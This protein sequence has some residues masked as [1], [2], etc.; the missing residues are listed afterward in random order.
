MNLIMVRHAHDIP[1]AGAEFKLSIQGRKQARDTADKI[2][3]LGVPSI[4]AA[5]S[6]P[7]QRS[8]ET[9]DE[10][11]TVLSPE[12]RDAVTLLQP[13]SSVADLE[14]L[15]FDLAPQKPNTIILVGHEP[16]LSN[17]VLQWCGLPDNDQLDDGRPPW[18]LA[19]GEAMSVFPDVVSSTVY[20]HSDLIQM[21]GRKRPLPHSKPL[22][23]AGVF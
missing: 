5:L 15:L 2:A 14:T 12:R 16:Q 10:M 1:G 20:L 22:S 18:T 19:R 6:S 4:D 23:Q 21:L 3:S 13:G 11:C 8:V 17:A 9:L 7:A